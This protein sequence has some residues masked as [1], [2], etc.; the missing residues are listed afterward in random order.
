MLLNHIWGL[1]TTP[2]QEWRLIRNESN[3]VSK[4]YLTHVLLLAAIPAIC[5][6]IGFT[7]VGWSVGTDKL[8]KL[9]EANA[10]SMALLG[11]MAMLA[12][13]FVMGCFIQWMAKTY[14]ANT[15]LSQTIVFAAYTATPLFLTGL[16]ALLPNVWL[17]LFLVI[18]GAS[19]A[20]YL[21]YTGIPVM[22]KVPKE[23]GFL[24]ASSVLCVGLVVLVSM[25]TITV[26]F[27]GI[28]IG[29]SQVVF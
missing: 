19:Y 3:S 6:Y 14:H 1:F 2:Q 29:P 5:G 8:V 27:W 20:T 4:I 16:G 9:T 24:F 22:M 12:G 15:T 10:A 7:Q 26:L 11:Y 17:N 13:I 28:G 25:I 23:V 21:L 18:A